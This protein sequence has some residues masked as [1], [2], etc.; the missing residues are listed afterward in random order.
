M[1]PR[2]RHF[3]LERFSTARDRER[4]ANTALGGSSGRV[5]ANFEFNERAPTLQDGE[6]HAVIGY[7][8]STRDARLSKAHLAA[9][10]SRGPGPFSDWAQKLASAQR[11][12]LR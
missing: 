9:Y 1:P 8:A 5:L 4:L 6:L 11:A 3:A 10:L 2:A 7:V 12:P